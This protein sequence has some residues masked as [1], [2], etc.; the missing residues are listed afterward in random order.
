M[1]QNEEEDYDEWSEQN[2]CKC[3]QRVCERFSDVLNVVLLFVNC[4]VPALV[5]GLDCNS[6][7]T[8][9]FSCECIATIIIRYP[10]NNRLTW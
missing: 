4:L 8:M 1:R 10:N 3:C 7:E 2:E 5:M 6:A 9:F